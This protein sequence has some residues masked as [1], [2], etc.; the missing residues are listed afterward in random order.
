VRMSIVASKSGRHVVIMRSCL[1]SKIPLSKA[2][3][4]ISRVRPLAMT[5]VARSCLWMIIPLRPINGCGSGR[6]Q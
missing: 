6:Y 3:Q 4:A 5:N 2:Q 1:P